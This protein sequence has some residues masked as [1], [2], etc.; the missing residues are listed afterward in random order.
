[1]HRRPATTTSPWPPTALYRLSYIK[2]NSAYNGK[3]NSAGNMMHKLNAIANHA[4]L[5]W[6]LYLYYTSKDRFN[7]N[8]THHWNRRSGR[9]TGRGGPLCDVRCRSR[10]RR[11]RSL[12]SCR[13]RILERVHCKSRTL[14]TFLVSYGF[15]ASYCKR[16]ASW[17]NGRTDGRTACP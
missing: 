1:M 3:C 14:M 13:L 17:S 10:R 6:C 12:S 11:Y 4:R 7:R 2:T 15:I 16:S 5:L 9:D 8:S